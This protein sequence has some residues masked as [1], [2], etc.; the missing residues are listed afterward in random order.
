MHFRVYLW[1]RLAP[2]HPI[3]QLR[4]AD[5]IQLARCKSKLSTEHT[6]LPKLDFVASNVLGDEN[7]RQ[8][9]RRR[10]RITRLR[11]RSQEQKGGI[12]LV[13]HCF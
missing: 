2:G 4:A 12:P 10:R 7:D 9:A 1:S 6:V 3:L 5:A 8:L 13:S 11:D